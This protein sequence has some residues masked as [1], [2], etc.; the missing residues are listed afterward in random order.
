MALDVQIK[1]DVAFLNV[2]EDMEKFITLAADK[3]LIDMSNSVEYP[4]LDVS[5]TFTNPD[6]II[7]HSAQ[8]LATPRTITLSGDCS[9]SVEFDGSGNVTI[10]TTVTGGTP[11]AH[12]HV[13]ADITDATNLNEASKIVKRDAS[14]NFTA[15]IITAALSGNAS[16]ATL[17]AGATNVTTNINGH[18]ISSIFES[19]GTTVK[20]ATAAGSATNATN[21]DT[22]DSKHYSDIV[23]DINNISLINAIIFA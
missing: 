16:T 3:L 22:L 15:N 11:T 1:K 18:A 21:A 7:A 13:T 17:A 14:G 8:V 2:I 23:S 4:A 12:T 5:G 9:G 19:N 10:T 20:L 6:G